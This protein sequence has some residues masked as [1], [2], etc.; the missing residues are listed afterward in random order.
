VLIRALRRSFDNPDSWSNPFGSTTGL[1][2][3]G[4]PFRGR[5]GYPLEIW[6][7]RLMKA[8]HD[9]PGFLLYPETMQT[10][11]PGNAYL[12]EI[13]F[14]FGETRCEDNPIPLCCFYETE[15]SPVGKLV[16]DKD[17]EASL[18]PERK[19]R[20]DKNTKV[21]LI[22]VALTNSN[23]SSSITSYQRTRLVSI[24]QRES[25]DTHYPDITII[26]PSSEVLPI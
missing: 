10:A 20:L 22:E 21:S 19:A 24:C 25:L 17:Q 5:A 16:N 23:R 4:T 1:I 12:R 9:K 3:F 14:A 26:Y 8:H 15:P 13:V 18:N 6:V 7:D 11:T 2:F